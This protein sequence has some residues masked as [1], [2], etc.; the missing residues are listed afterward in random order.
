MWIGVVAVT[1]ILHIGPIQGK[2]TRLPDGILGAA[3]FFGAYTFIHLN[4]IE[5]SETLRQI[6]C[7][8]SLDFPYFSIYLL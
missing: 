8:I 4:H 3:S 2:F 5:I 1:F 6:K 7:S